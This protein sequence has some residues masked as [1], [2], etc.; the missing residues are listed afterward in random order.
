MLIYL[1]KSI[2]IS[3]NRERAREEGSVSQEQRLGRTG[4]EISHSGLVQ[5]LAGSLFRKTL[6]T[7][8]ANCLTSDRRRPVDEMGILL[9]IRIN[10]ALELA[11]RLLYWPGCGRAPLV[12]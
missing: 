8:C 5:K 4:C 9:L 10:L 7:P 2:G 12:V 3:T 1:L 6:S 11:N